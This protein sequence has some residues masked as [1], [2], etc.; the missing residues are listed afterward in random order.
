MAR[1]DARRAE[2][3]FSRAEWARA[4]DVSEMTIRRGVAGDPSPSATTIAKLRNGLTALRG[5]NA[6]GMVTSPEAVRALGEA[7]TA[8]AAQLLGVPVALCHA[9]SPQH[10]TRGASADVL[11]R[12][13]H[14]ARGLTFYMLNQVYGVSQAAIA[15]AY[16]MAKPPICRLIPQIE[17]ARDDAGFD[18]VV[19]Q[20]A[21]SVNRASALA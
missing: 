12:K 21:G 7:L 9:V 17:D 16:Q 10:G 1:L 19:L 6:G 14:L 13:A 8:T 15:R 4:A 18:A 5:E 20:M 3:G 2:E 11:T